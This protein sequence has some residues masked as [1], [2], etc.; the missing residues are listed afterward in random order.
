[1][2]AVHLTGNGGLDKLVVRDDIPVPVPGDGEVLVAVG[3]CGV[4]NTDINTRIAWYSKAVSC[5]TAAGGDGGFAHAG[6]DDSTWGGSGLAIL[7]FHT[8]ARCRGRIQVHSSR[9]RR[10]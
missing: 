1:M 6:A 5:D 10:S 2:R 4:N 9:T 3:A 8:P 7:R